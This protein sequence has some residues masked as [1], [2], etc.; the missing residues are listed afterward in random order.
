M[1]GR[2]SRFVP[3]EEVIIRLSPGSS[4]SSDSG[5][6]DDAKW[7]WRDVQPLALIARKSKDADP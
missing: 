4:S 5:R 6:C 1:H 7:M 3:Y 2:V